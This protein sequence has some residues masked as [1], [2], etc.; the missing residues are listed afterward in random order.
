[1]PTVLVVKHPGGQTDDLWKATSQGLETQICRE[2]AGYKSWNGWIMWDTTRSDG[3]LSIQWSRGERLTP[4]EVEDGVSL[5]VVF[6][7]GLIRRL[8]Q[9]NST[10]W[11][12]LWTPLWVRAQLG[13]LLKARA[14]GMGHLLLPLCLPWEM[15]FRNGSPSL[16]TREADA[17]LLW[18]ALPSS[19]NWTYWIRWALG[20]FKC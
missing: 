19:E 12:W 6:R 16:A 20:P 5:T 2:H 18:P 15:T 1:M 14:C 7:S 9:M 13:R 4:E 17:L 10:D 3:N 11:K 8:P